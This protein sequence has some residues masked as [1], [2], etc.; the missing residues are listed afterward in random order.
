MGKSWTETEKR[1]W[2]CLTI[3]E[4][5]DLQPGSIV[6]ASFIKQLCTEPN[7]ISNLQP[8]GIRVRGSNIE[9]SLDLR[10][11]NI[12]FNL[13]L[14]QC[15]IPDTLDL[16]HAAIKALDLS[17]SK[18]DSID[19]D[20]LTVFGNF[21]LADEF[22]AA[23]SV[24]LM[25]AKIEGDLIC[26]R[27]CFDNQNNQKFD[28]QKTNCGGSNTTTSCGDCRKSTLHSYSLVLERVYI[29]G[30]V[31]LCDGFSAFGGVHLGDSTINGN[32]NCTNGKFIKRSGCQKELS[33][34][35]RLT[36]YSEAEFH[37]ACAFNGEGMHVKR[38]MILNDINVEGEIRLTG[39]LIEG[40]LDSAGGKYKN[41]GANAIYGDR[42]HVKGNAFFCDRFE[43]EGIIRFPCARIGADISFYN[44]MM[45]GSDDNV[46]VLYCEGIKVQ[47]TFYLK[48]FETRKGYIN[49]SHAT[50]SGNL[51]CTNSKFL[52]E[53]VFAINAKGMSISGSVFLRSFKEKNLE[54]FDRN[55]FLANAFVCLTG[56]KLGMDLVCTGGHFKLGKPCTLE[57]PY[58]DSI[59]AG[60]MS[61]GGKVEMDEIE[62]EG[63]VRISDTRIG[64]YLNCN[65]S[66]I[67]T[68][69]HEGDHVYAFT[70]GK[71]HVGGSLYLGD[72]FTAKG[73]V[74]LN[75]A[76]IGRNIYLNSGTIKNE[77]DFSL[78]A[79]QM[80]V[81]G[82]IIFKNLISHGEIKI[83]FSV[84]GGNLDCSGGEFLNDKSKTERRKKRD[85]PDEELERHYAFR[86][87][88]LKT[89]GSVW[90]KDFKVDGA[91]SF[92]GAV[93]GRN[94]YWKGV[95]DSQKVSL[96]LD[97]AKV[98][99]LV[100][101][102][103]S[104]PKQNNLQINDF[105]YQFI[106]D[107]GPEEL[108]KRREKWLSL[109]K[110]FRT[111]PYEQLAKVLKRSGHLEEAK[112]VLIK[113][114]NH[115]S[116]NNSMNFI[117][118]KVGP[119]LRK[120][121]AWWHN[122]LV[123]YGYK[124]FRA[125]VIGLFIVLFGSFIFYSGFHF[126]LMVPSEYKGG[127]QVANLSEPEQVQTVQVANFLGRKCK[128]NRR[129]TDTSGFYYFFYSLDTFLPIVDF[130][131]AAYWLPTAYP[132]VENGDEC[133]G[134]FSLW[135][136]ILC[137]FRWFVIICGWIVTSVFITALSGVVRK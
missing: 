54:D 96:F 5:A 80:Q 84:I 110:D 18:T 95:K 74:M 57:N 11:L 8:H 45:N 13:S 128:P 24:C 35:R 33:N 97:A 23:G 51:D 1:V 78:R 12:P 53:G 94:F 76:S 115:Q 60:N 98:E 36:C 102:I 92:Q 34:G 120:K 43:A 22:S 17:G 2:S 87:I 73:E 44:G 65:Q 66:K 127:Y 28:T 133:S 31:Y 20:G 29:K 114:H 50:I 48:K 93:I 129:I 72:G 122:F 86:A 99:V 15:S 91:V 30:S 123:G 42:M 21:R 125:A 37:D 10:L 90:F 109:S 119:K 108:E 59:Q 25:G 19:A 124:P 62:T 75:D 77:G 61:I 104:W 85:S 46:P 38:N 79:M 106:R 83:D 130:Q 100:D 14:T 113:K 49:L 88:G 47:G 6:R 136:W 112:L 134:K 9:G 137:V 105:E 67:S 82:S 111:Q 56:S 131:T 40:D 39:A 132:Q 27:G 70:G 107:Q 55:I 4:I 103:D 26:T 69:T 32:L 41:K 121:L 68:P 52:N 64:S 63:G 7:L 101:D 16:R 126:D 116:G 135:G 3:G 71:L 117:M 58:F 89:E 81:A 118:K